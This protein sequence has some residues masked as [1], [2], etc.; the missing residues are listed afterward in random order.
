MDVWVETEDKVTDV[1]T[2]INGITYNIGL[3]EEGLKGIYMATGVNNVTLK[4]GDTFIFTDF[5]KA[6]NAITEAYRKEYSK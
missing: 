5:Q 6:V 3:I 2:A 1:K 4:D